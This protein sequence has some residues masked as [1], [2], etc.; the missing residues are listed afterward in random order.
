MGDFTGSWVSLVVGYLFT[1]SL[2][3]RSA[4]F[5]PSGHPVSCLL[6]KVCQLRIIFMFLNSSIF[7]SYRSTYLIAF[8][9][10]LATQSP[11]PEIFTTW[12]FQTKFAGSCSKGSGRQPLP[13]PRTL[14][15]APVT[16]IFSYLTQ[17]IS[18]LLTGQDP[19]TTLGDHMEFSGSS[20]SLGPSEADPVHLLLLS[21]PPDLAEAPNH[22]MWALTF[23]WVGT[24]NLQA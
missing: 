21:P 14:S 3:Q 18:H 4:P 11:K 10:S 22:Q 6:F 24:C 16:S 5:Q 1:C 12:F 17:A 19:R 7:N 8:I 15:A 20:A 13:P 2:K 9:V 23:P